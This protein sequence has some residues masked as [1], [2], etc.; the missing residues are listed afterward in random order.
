MKHLII[1]G[2]RGWGR[3][4]Y[5]AAKGTKAYQSGEYDIKGFLDSKADAF[6]GLKGEY[7]PILGAPETYEIQPDDVFF[8]AMGEPKWRKYYAEMM[9][10]KGATFMSIISARSNVNATATI[11]D[12][13]FVAGWSVI[14]DNVQLGKHTVVHVFSDLG[15]DAKVGDYSTIEAYVFLGGYAEVGQESVMHVR[16]TL[17]R[18]KKIGNQVEVGSSSVVMRNVKDGLHMF[19]NPAQKIDY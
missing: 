6:E 1:V 10:A 5:A 3:E 16:S 4:V 17:I 19:G 13:S 9:E 18:H 8:I 7:P 14:S 11:G 12:G 2:A 15:H